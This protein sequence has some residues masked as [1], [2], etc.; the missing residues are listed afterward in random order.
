LRR[1]DILE[2]VPAA[3]VVR[4]ELRHWGVG[5]MA[6]DK[7]KSEPGEDRTLQEATRDLALLQTELE[8]ARAHGE[9]RRIREKRTISEAMLDSWK[10][11]ARMALTFGGLLGVLLLLLILWRISERVEADTETVTATFELK[12]AEVETRIRAE[13]AGGG[14]QDLALELDIL[15]L[16]AIPHARSDKVS[17]LDSLLKLVG[18]DIPSDARKGLETLVKTSGEALGNLATAVKTIREA[19]PGSP[20]AIG[21][22]TP[23][24]SG[25]S[26]QVNLVLTGRCCCAGS[27]PHS[28]TGAPV[29]S[30]DS[31]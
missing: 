20:A 6:E 11:I 29:D 23:A 28:R 3:N 19:F 31:G 22:T 10:S 12:R 4:H 7:A 25:A 1:K 18:S 27:S 5:R 14:S 24:T 13:R 15:R 16:A 9:L 2:L 21:A 30:D 26:N 8:I 17:V